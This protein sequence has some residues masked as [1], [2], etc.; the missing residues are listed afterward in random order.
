V[1]S[2]SVPSVE[3]ELD[4]IT[5]AQQGDRR[6]FGELV[7]RHRQG[8][9]NVVYRMCGDAN[10]AE[11]AAQEAFIRAWQHLSSYRPRAPFRN[12]VYR[13]ATNAALDALRREQK[14]VDIDA[15]SLAAGGRGPEATV[16]GKERAERVQQAV[17]VLP[18]ASRVVL[19]LREYEGLSYREIAD[20]LGIP[21]GTV[22]SRLNY[23]R[24]RLRESLAPYLET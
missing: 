5:R 19:V 23:A 11:D 3:T 14:T 12:W 6:A 9:V 2:W 21:I 17:L 22:M 15:L 7:R 10:L 16:E 20:T 4:L 24:N 18:P 8:V 13:I 1:K